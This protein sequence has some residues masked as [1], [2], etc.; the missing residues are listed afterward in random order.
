MFRAF[1]L[2]AIRQIDE[3]YGQ[4]GSDLELCW[5]VLR[6]GKRIMILPRVRVIHHGGREE[7]ALLA[8]DRQ[9]GMAAYLTKHRGMV[10]GLG[11]RT[12]AVL[13]AL[14]GMRL[15]QLQYLLAGQKIDGSQG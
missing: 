7:T 4:F 11:A 3:R 9:L 10:S 5:Q 6:S 12:G 14:A 2:R 1:F 15:R 13:K 8:A